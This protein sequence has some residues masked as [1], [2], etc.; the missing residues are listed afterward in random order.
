MNT[1][2]KS[3]LMSPAEQ[4][5][6]RA[7]ITTKVLEFLVVEIFSSTDILQ[8]FLGYKTRLGCIKSLRRLVKSGFLKESDFDTLEGRK[9]KLWG[10]TSAGVYAISNP[11][12]LPE[13]VRAFEPSKVSLR[14]LPHNLAI[15]QVTSQLILKGFELKH[16]SIEFQN[17]NRMPDAVMVEKE[18]GDS[19]SLEIELTIK[20]TN[21]YLEII[22][23]YQEPLEEKA[24]NS[25]IWLMPDE[26]KLNRL[27]NVFDNIDMIF[28][29]RHQMFTLE[30]FNT[31]E[32]SG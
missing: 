25:V 12:E 32:L 1:S 19:I 2:T 15:H 6:R 11:D 18:S 23:A 13:R 29:E 31:M 3:H 9:I 17:F 5:L 26:N 4:A 28:R 14:M 7:E 24:I 30:K 22:E 21:R 8:R 20:T 10:I 27:I 16:A